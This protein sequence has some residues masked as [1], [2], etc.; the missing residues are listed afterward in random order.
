MNPTLPLPA[1]GVVLH[2]TPIQFHIAGLLA[3]ARMAGHDH[4]RK[5]HED[6][7]DQSFRREGYGLLAEWLLIE[8]LERAGLCPTDYCLLSDVAPTGPD[9]RQDDI[10]YDVKAVPPGQRYLCRNEAQRLAHPDRWL[11]PVVF[12]RP[13]TAVVYQA[14]PPDQVAEWPL[15]DDGH[16]P[17][18]SVDVRT[19]CPLPS[20]LSLAGRE[21]EAR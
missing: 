15:R 5:R 7:G 11:L 21:E 16:A 1:D 19:L 20:L 10:P 12:I 6:L 14:V 3:K 9:F 18:R 2:A 17:Y 4:C 8:A 13:C